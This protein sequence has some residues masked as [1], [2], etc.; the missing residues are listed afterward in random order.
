LK[1]LGT[2][3]VISFSFEPFYSVSYVFDLACCHPQVKIGFGELDLCFGLLGFEDPQSNKIYQD[4]SPFFCANLRETRDCALS[5]AFEAGYLDVS[6]AENVLY[7]FSCDSSAVPSID[8][9]G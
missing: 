7:W 8:S 2:K 1:K 5:V 3:N 9:M 4:P 6:G